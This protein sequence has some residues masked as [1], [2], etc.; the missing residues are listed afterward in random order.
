MGGCCPVHYLFFK[1]NCCWG[2]SLVVQRLGHCAFTDEVLG[3][4]LGQGT[5]IPHDKWGIP[6]KNH[7]WML[8]S[9]Y[10]LY[11]LGTS[12]TQPPKCDNGMSTGRANVPWST[13]SPQLGIIYLDQQISFSVLRSKLCVCVFQL[14]G[15]SCKF[16]H[17]IV[18]PSFK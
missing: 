13:K 7:S 5:K 6:L 9:I 11:V 18:F 16:S 17:F 1:K 2:N 15:N 4:I 8:S 3:S 12:D 14:R 10:D